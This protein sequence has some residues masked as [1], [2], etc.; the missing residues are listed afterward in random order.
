M[1]GS[2][3]DCLRAEFGR[4]ASPSRAATPGS[5]SDPTQTIHREVCRPCLCWL[6][7]T[8]LLNGD[9]QRGEWQV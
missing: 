5:N 3:L 7:L 9:R 6:P 4:R 8:E 2:P 1:L